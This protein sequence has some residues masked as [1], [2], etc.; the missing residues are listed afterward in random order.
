MGIHVGRCTKN[1][2]I[3]MHGL[4]LEELNAFIRVT[5]GTLAQAWPVLARRLDNQGFL[6]GIEIS[7]RKVFLR[8]QADF[9]LIR[10]LQSGHGK[11]SKLPTFVLAT[12]SLMLIGFLSLI[13]LGSGSEGRVVKNKTTPINHCDYKNLSKWLEGVSENPEALAK[14]ATI[15]GGVTVGI[16]E[17]KGSRYSYTLGSEKPKRVLKLQK[18]DS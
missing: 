8:T 2:S 17:C 3:Q 10:A 15:L 4:K 13:P 11:K 16:I 7:K 14:E 9:S 12:A 6:D 18:L 5:F 1:K